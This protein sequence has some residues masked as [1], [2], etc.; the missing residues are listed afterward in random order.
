M[1]FSSSRL[2]PA[3]H[4]TG[5]V[6]H[7]FAPT[8]KQKFIVSLSYLNDHMTD[9]WSRS[10]GVLAHLKISHVGSIKYLITD[11]IVAPAL[12]LV[13]YFYNLQSS[14]T[15]DNVCFAQSH[16]MH[17]LTSNHHRDAGQLRLDLIQLKQRK[18]GYAGLLLHFS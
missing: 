13:L 9:Y 5:E 14:F 11:L 10:P 16:I 1:P 3:S 18:P 17:A 2:E 4:R 8:S 15:T 7:L 6:R 12:Y